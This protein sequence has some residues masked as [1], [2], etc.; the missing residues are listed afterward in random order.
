MKLGN[1]FKRSQPEEYVEL[2]HAEQP[3]GGKTHIEIEN[4]NDFAD[5][6]RLQK[7]VRDGSVLLVKVRDLRLKDMN[8]LKKAIARVRK[9]CLAIDGD[10]TGVGDDWLILAPASAR[11]QREQE[12]V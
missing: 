4:L 7:K 9:T 1:I 2:G 8:E 3:A 10:I 11:I 6:D 12:R 5:S